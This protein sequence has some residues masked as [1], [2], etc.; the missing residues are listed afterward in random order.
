[1]GWF[2][3]AEDRQKL[4]D[5][6]NQMEEMLGDSNTSSPRKGFNEGCFLFNSLP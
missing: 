3:S 1:M 4:Q 6:N 5:L 2:D